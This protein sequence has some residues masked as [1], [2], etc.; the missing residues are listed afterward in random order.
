MPIKMSTF[1][2]YKSWNQYIKNSSSLGN[3]I[4][5]S[6]RSNRKRVVSLKNP[7]VISYENSNSYVSWKNLNFFTMNIKGF[8]Q[9]WEHLADRTLD[10][11]SLRFEFVAL[12]IEQCRITH[13]CLDYPLTLCNFNKCLLSYPNW[14]VIIKWRYINVI[15]RLS[16]R[17]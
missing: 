2:L 8:L 10:Q 11:H 17:V 5:L 13:V 6:A 4:G 15:W 12:S 9:Y 14:A 16:S 1:Y 3:S 7:I